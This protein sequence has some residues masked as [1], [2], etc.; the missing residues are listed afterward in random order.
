MDSSRVFAGSGST[1]LASWFAA[2]RCEGCAAGRVILVA[3]LVLLAILLPACGGADDDPRVSIESPWPTSA[4][5][6]LY[7]TSDETVRLAGSVEN[8]QYV[9]AGNRT[10]GN[11]TEAQ[12][13]YQ[14]QRGNWVAELRLQPGTN[15]ILVTAYGDGGGSMTTRRIDVTR[16]ER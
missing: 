4:T 14:G 7:F 6:A 9:R 1:S 12:I 15:T 10:V 11:S 16:I 2:H 8:A 3:L 5:Q 13:V